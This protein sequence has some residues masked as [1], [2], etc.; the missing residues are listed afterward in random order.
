[1]ENAMKE[2]SNGEI[3]VVWKS[4]LCQ[5][6]GFCVKGLPGVFNLQARPWVNVQGATTRQI[7]EQVEKCP[8][9]AL[10]YFA[11]KKDDHGI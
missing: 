1:M 8:S 9:G 4:A 3:T 7:I 10:S 11:E 2:Y 5:H 6:A